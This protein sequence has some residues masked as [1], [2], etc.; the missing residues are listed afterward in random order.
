L[1]HLDAEIAVIESHFARFASPGWLTRSRMRRRR[2]LAFYGAARGFQSAGESRE[3]WRWFARAYR[4]SPF[5][6]RMHAA[7]ILN[8]L[9]PLRRSSA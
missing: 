8:L 7:V 9:A 2:A 5:I 3:A 4:E 6:L 1:R